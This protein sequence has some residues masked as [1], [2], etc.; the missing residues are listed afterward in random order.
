ME[1]RRLNP[2]DHP[3]WLRLRLALW[4]DN[5]PQGLEAEMQEI[6]ADPKMPVFVLAR[7][8]GGLGGFIEVALRPWAEGCATRPVGYIEGWYVDPDLRRAGVGKALVQT[9]EAWAA[10]QGCSEMASDCD[11]WNTIS[12]QAHLA[13]GYQEAN[14]I[15][16]FHKRLS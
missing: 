7:P 16:L 1:I 9:A 14:R 6:L 5:T 11:L 4:P 13:L 8:E 12:F 15:I 10:S 2:A 3:E